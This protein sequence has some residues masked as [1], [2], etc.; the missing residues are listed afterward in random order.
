M[1]KETTFKETCEFLE[2]HGWERISIKEYAITKKFN[3]YE[4]A[5]VGDNYFF[6][7]NK[8]REEIKK[9]KK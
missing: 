4:T 3:K 7:L 2:T 9:V 6:R 5:M 8:S 1:T